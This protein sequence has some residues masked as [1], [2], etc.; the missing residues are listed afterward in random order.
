LL[1]PVRRHGRTETLLLYWFRTPPYVKVGRSALDGDAMRRLEEQ[2]PDITFD[3]NRILREPPQALPENEATRRKEQRDARAARRKRKRPQGDEQG[4][5][6]RVQDSGRATAEAATAE[7]DSEGEAAPDSDTDFGPKETE[8]S[9]DAPDVQSSEGS[10]ATASASPDAP[11][12]SAGTGKRRKRRR[13]RR[14]K[15]P[16]GTP[17]GGAPPTNS[18]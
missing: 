3:W 14:G 12:R 18:V 6:L 4:S 7:D 16:G 5:G 10:G 17:S 9:L 1:H 15:P 11:S 2:Y 13:R 8:D